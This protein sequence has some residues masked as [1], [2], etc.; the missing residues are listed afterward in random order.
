MSSVV[1]HPFVLQSAT[2]HRDF[3]RVYNDHNV[4]LRL[5]LFSAVGRRVLAAE[6]NCGS[7]NDFAVVHSLGVENVINDAFS[8]KTVIPTAEFSLVVV[9]S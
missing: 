6:V 5:S 9:N 2:R 7:G 1:F 4:A 8:D 3:I